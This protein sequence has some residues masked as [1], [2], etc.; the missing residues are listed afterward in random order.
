MSYKYI[1]GPVPSRRL[2]ISLGVDLAPHKTCTANC[3]YCECGKTTRLTVKRDEYVPGDI[4]LEEIDDCLGREPELDYVT[5]SGAGEPTLHSRMGEIAEFIKAKRSGYRLALLTNSNLFYDKQ[6]REEALNLD[7]VV[8]SIDAASPEIFRKINRPHPDLSVE[9]MVAGLAQFAGSFKGQLWIEVFLAAGINDDPA[10]MEK[11]GGVIR[12]I[13][14]DRVQINT[15]DRPGTEPWVRPVDDAAIQNAINCFGKADL[16]A[17][18]KARVLEPN[19]DQDIESL[20]L[21]TIMRRPCTIEDM[22]RTLGVNEVHARKHVGLLLKSGLIASQ[23][24]PRGIFY[25]AC[26]K[27]NGDQ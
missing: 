25:S 8:A 17:K 21:S 14:P 12:S 10:E 15:L 9:G 24:L 26:H 23:R 5:F 2:G 4:V 22:A 3:V 7:L 13:R 16:I 1:F 18:T 11:I 20:I 6:V 27:Q 19:Q